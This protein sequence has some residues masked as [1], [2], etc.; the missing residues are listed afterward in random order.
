LLGGFHG[1]RL[2][3]CLPG[4]LALGGFFFTLELFHLSGGSGCDGLALDSFPPKSLGP[5]PGVLGRGLCPV[6]HADSFCFS[7]PA[8]SFQLRLAGGSRGFRPFSPFDFDTGGFARSFRLDGH[9]TCLTFSHFT[10]GLELCGS[11]TDFPLDN[12]QG[13]GIVCGL[14]Y[15]LHLDRFMG[16]PLFAGCSEGLFGGLPG[17]LEFLGFVAGFC[18]CHRTP[19]GLGSG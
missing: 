4:C 8:S 14:Q 12:F 16:R 18:F 13:T 9:R 17:D 11:S 10:R 7:R 5:D 3:L 15:S 2:F 6:G 19:P 1:F